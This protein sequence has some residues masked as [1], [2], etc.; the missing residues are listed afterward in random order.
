MVPLR[1]TSLYSLMC[2]TRANFLLHITDLLLRNQEQYCRF[3]ISL[4]EFYTYPQITASQLPLVKNLHPS[5]RKQ[6]DKP[7]KLL[8]N[9]E[10][11]SKS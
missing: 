1:Q 4:H 6:Q 10:S 3:Q 2:N 5:K 9:K 7:I 11:P 8:M